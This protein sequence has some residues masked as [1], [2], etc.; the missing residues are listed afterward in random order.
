MSTHLG[1]Q[2]APIL[3]A[4]ARFASFDQHLRFVLGGIVNA[5][6]QGTGVAVFP[7]RVESQRG[8]EI[9]AEAEDGRLNVGI[10]FHWKSSSK[11]SDGEGVVVSK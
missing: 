5:I 8:H 4:H 7:K 10:H 2:G 9:I 1:F 6:L 11:S 3:A